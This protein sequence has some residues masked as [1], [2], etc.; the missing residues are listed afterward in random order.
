MEIEPPNLSVPLEKQ[1][2]W[3]LVLVGACCLVVAI[4]ALISPSFAAVFGT[5]SIVGLPVLWLLLFSRQG[6]SIFVAWGGLGRIAFFVVV[7]GYIALAK[8]VLV[9]NLVGVIERVLG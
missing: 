3:G 5:S 2:H 8:S 4:S 9:P 6:S 7:F 1:E